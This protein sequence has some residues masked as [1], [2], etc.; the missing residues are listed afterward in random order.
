MYAVRIGVKIF[1]NMYMMVGYDAS[2]QTVKYLLEQG[3]DVN[4]LD[5]VRILFT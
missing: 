2:S 3:A 5:L 4:V 1:A